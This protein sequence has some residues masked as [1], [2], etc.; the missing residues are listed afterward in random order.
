MMFKNPLHFILQ[1]LSLVLHPPHG[2]RTFELHD[3]SMPPIDLFTVFP[4]LMIRVH[5]ISTSIFPSLSL[6]FRGASGEF[7]NTGVAVVG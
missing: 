7:R 5:H 1:M 3:T 2:P 6:V 4:V